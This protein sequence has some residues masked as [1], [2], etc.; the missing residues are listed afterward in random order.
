MKI[1][2]ILNSIERGVA[3][4][5]FPPRSQRSA[6]A[7]KNT[8]KALKKY[9]PLYVSMTCGAGGSNYETTQDAVNILLEEKDL[10]VMP[11][12]TCL[13]TEPAAVG[14]ILK[15]YR[16]LGIANIMALRG[17]ILPESQ[18]ANRGG[19]FKFAKDLVK[20]IKEYGH[21]DIGAAVYPEGHIEMTSLDQDLKYTKEKIDSGVNFAVTQMFFD[22]KYYYQFLERARSNGINIPILPGILPL[23]NIAKVKEFASICRA[24]IP[25]HIEEELSR[26]SGNPKDMQ[27]AGIELTIKQCKDLIDHGHQRLHFFTLNKASVMQ[28]IIEALF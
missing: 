6:A 1:S 9:N 15:D 3:F 7:L 16:D 20:L 18:E 4:E 26:F 27:K 13:S 23:T 19:E 10:T 21:F 11:H 2:Q 8:L 22:N 17:D 25:A 28:E 12:L 24:T 14:E 5:F